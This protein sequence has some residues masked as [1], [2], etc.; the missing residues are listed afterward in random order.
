MGR[1]GEG[2]KSG[3]LSSSMLKRAGRRRRE[4]RK[5]GLPLQAH[6]SIQSV[7]EFA[8]FLRNMQEFTEIY[9]SLQEY[10]RV[11]RNM[12]E[13]T[14]VYR[15]NYARVYRNMQDFTEICKSLQKYARVYRNMQ[16]F[17]GICKSLQEVVYCALLFVSGTFDLPG[18]HSAKSPDCLPSTH[19]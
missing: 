1:G 19:V 6:R 8:R 13:L 17:T 11:Y 2:G 3:H 5:C 7:Q 4:G 14:R 12:Q 15:N 16:E 10:A 9:K 18:S